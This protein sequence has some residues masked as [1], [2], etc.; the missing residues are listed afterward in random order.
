MPIC[1]SGQCSP[2]K[3][4]GTTLYSSVSNPSGQITGSKSAFTVVQPNYRSSPQSLTKQTEVDSEISPISLDR[5]NNLIWMNSHSSSLSRSTEEQTKP[6]WLSPLCPAVAIQSTQLPSPAQHPLPQPPPFCAWSGVFP[7]PNCHILATS[8]HST[9][10]WSFTRD[11]H[12]ES[13]GEL[14][15]RPTFLL[16]N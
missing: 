15:I 2:T 9:G 10:L 11:P 16:T 12:C 1:L 8:E 5:G 14:A 4:S 6:T 3:F 13:G 7:I